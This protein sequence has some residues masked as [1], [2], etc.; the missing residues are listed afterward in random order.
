MAHT[1]DADKQRTNKWIL[2][3]ATQRIALHE[4]EQNNRA[5]HQTASVRTTNYFQQK[6]RPCPS[7][8]M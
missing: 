4:Y 6:S 2:E 5:K 7:L 3:I 8:S 1:T